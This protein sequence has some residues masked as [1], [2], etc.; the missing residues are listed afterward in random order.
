MKY[1]YL[2]ESGD[3][4]FNNKSSKFFVIAIVTANGANAL[5]KRVNKNTAILLGKGWPA[6]EEIKGNSLWIS[7]R[8][9]RIPKQISDNRISYISK[10]IKY[11]CE[12]DITVNY[13]VFRKSR[14]SPHLK[15]ADNAYIY[16]YFSYLLLCEMH[17][18]ELLKTDINFT[19]DMRSKETHKQMPFNGYIQTRLATDLDYPHEMVIKHCDSSQVK[20]LQA[21]DFLCWS[22]FRK[23][24]HGDDQF[25]NLLKPK[26]FAVKRWYV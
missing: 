11:L 19:V 7:P 20:G 3:L 1:Y 22:I 12:G 18:K 21:V 8:R 13:I 14:I 15:R 23:Y 6:D 26:L 9:P 17:K 25:Y 5:K 4:G 10:T 24:E 2:D 16:N